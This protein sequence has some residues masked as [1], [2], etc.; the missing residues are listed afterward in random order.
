MIELP[1]PCLVVLVGPPGAGKSTWA[2][3][4]LPDAAVSSDAMRA[5]VGEGIHDLRAS[6]DAFELVDHIVERRL[7]RGL[8]TVVDSLGTEAGRRER[9]R[10]IAARHG[11]P[12]VAVVFDVPAA[13]VRRQN[14]ERAAR[15]PDSVIDA[16]LTE[17]PRTLA[18]VAAEPFAVVHRAESAAVV[19]PV[20]MRSNRSARSTAT[21]N[22]DV[23]S[24]AKARTLRFG[25]QV[26][27]VGWSEGQA[28]TGAR[29]RAIAV[30]A[31]SAGFDGLW[32]MDHMRQIPMHGPPWADILESWTSL[33]HLSGC[34]ER[35][36]LGTLVTAL[37]F[38]NVAHL[39]KIIATLDVLSGGRVDCG[40]GLGWFQDEHVAYGLPFPTVDHRYAVLEDALQ[41]LPQMWGPGSKP[42]EGKV[43]R[44]PD[45]SCYPRPLQS[46]VPIMVGGSGERRTLRLV[47]QYA[48]A[49]NLF[50]DPATVTR[51]VNVLHRHC[52]NVGRDP[53]EVSV[54]H[55]STV[56]IG[57]DA[58][59]V[60]ALVDAARPARV[61]N[62]RYAR[63][64]NAG[65]VE[66]HVAR[67]DRYVEAGVD[68]II[69]SLI[70]LTA[71]GAAAVQRAGRVIA[72][73]R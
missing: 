64:V 49:C 63:S 68:H 35:I 61:S 73:C 19:P 50:G 22:S 53:A 11:V 25:L 1:S 8:T 54:S 59:H 7:H 42:F 12:C 29:L 31:E 33:A 6:T 28:V 4:H 48:D 30:A 37:T 20:L 3:T 47:A 69:V 58:A 55:L 21:I 52:R 56:L 45:T 44:V 34:T 9:W 43:L 70:D 14:R 41:L 72:A 51:K 27:V 18:A 32:M 16:F 15:V 62:E 10:S 26:P 39:A 67:V 71:S 13:Q 65:T 46:R 5:L 66:Q 17:W 38:R 2:A 36:R 40:I 24:P 23:A 60:R 57:D